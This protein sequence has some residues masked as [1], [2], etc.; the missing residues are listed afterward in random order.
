MPT[1][2]S[3]RYPQPSLRTQ[4]RER[5]GRLNVPESVLQREFSVKRR[6]IVGPAINVS[7]AVVAVGLAALG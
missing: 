7:Y 6:L 3:K 5:E 1:G 4:P 2:A